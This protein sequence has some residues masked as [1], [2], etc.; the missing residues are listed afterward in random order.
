MAAT[1]FARAI[2]FGPLPK[3]ATAAELL[4]RSVNATADPSFFTVRG[5]NSAMLFDTVAPTA[6]E[7]NTEEPAMALA[8][9][10]VAAMTCRPKLMLASPGALPARD[11]APYPVSVADTGPGYI[12]PAMVVLP[13]S[14]GSSSKNSGGYCYYARGC[15]AVAVH[16][17][18]LD[19][20]GF[21]FSTMQDVYAGQACKVSVATCSY[22]H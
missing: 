8:P 12:S 22:T 15:Q 14:G 10:Y 16:C 18:E 17:W 4:G 11:V 2:T 7:W 9:M 1:S 6:A 13:G 19:G 20:A 5:P 21:V 3:P